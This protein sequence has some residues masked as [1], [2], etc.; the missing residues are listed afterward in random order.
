MPKR[1]IADVCEQHGIT[2]DMLNVAVT[3]GVN[4]WNDDEMRKWVA[5]RRPRVDSKAKASPIVPPDSEIGDEVMTLEGLEDALLSA[6]DPREAGMRKVQIAG[7]R[8]AIKVRRERNELI[9]I[10]EIRERDT[11]IANAVRAACIKLENDLPPKGV[12]LDEAGMQ[13]AF[14]PVIRAILEA[15][16][17]SQSEFWADKEETPTKKKR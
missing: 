1:T 14:R 12:G 5:S 15:L 13:K 16:A 2:R 6:A 7:L 8:E 11:A 17:D 9:P 10:N 4:K 3:E